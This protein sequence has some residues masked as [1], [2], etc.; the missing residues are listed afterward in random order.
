MGWASQKKKEA[1][2]DLSKDPIHF[3]TFF[4]VVWLFIFWVLLFII[5]TRYFNPVVVLFVKYFSNVLGTILRCWEFNSEQNRECQRCKWRWHVS[6]RGNTK[7]KEVKYVLLQITAGLR[8]KESNE[9][10][11]LAQCALEILNW[12]PRE[13]L[14]KEYIWYRKWSSEPCGYFGRQNS[15]Y[16][17]PEAQEQAYRMRQK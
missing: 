5:Y 17:G 7:V 3:S 1:R 12:V 8:K 10:R 14:V 16:K 4:S 13:A 6:V 11:R 2:A 15:K 9:G